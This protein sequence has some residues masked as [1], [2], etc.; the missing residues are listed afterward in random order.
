MMNIPGSGMQGILERCDHGEEIALNSNSID[1]LVDRLCYVNFRQWKLEDDIRESTIAPE[2]ALALIRAIQASN[3]E[4]VGL[5]ERID[6]YF[7]EKERKESL[8]D[9]GEKV[10]FHET[11]GHILDALSILYI[12]KY[13]LKQL[14]AQGFD[15][16]RK[17]DSLNADVVAA[18]DEQIQLSERC[19]SRYRALL[20]EGRITLPPFSRFKMY[21]A[22][23]SST[24][25]N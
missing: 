7:V 16:H 11:L 12:R 20:R 10:E 6:R 21:G 15:R 19:F 9:A 2:R 3:S 18:I 17:N 14:I 24:K 5:I 8:D 23:N 25:E 4:R 1:G 13:H 22:P